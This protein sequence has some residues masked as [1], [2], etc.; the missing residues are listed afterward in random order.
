MRALELATMY[1]EL[2]NNENAFLETFVVVTGNKFLQGHHFQATQI[3]GV[4]H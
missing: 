4:S 2:D 3:I 1:S